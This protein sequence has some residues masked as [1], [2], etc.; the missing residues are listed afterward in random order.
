MA[1]AA[2]DRAT[3]LALSH[4]ILEAI[5]RHDAATLTH[6]LSEDFVLLAGD[7]RQER[8]AFLEHVRSAT[9]DARSFGFDWIDLHVVENTAVVA[10]VQRVEVVLDGQDVTSLGAFTDVFVRD[11]AGWRLAAAHSVDLMAG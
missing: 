1:E 9:F 10:G 11:W 3:L 6:C 7:G 8:A 4:T 5:V 2:D